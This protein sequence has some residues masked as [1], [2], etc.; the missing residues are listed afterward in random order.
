MQNSQNLIWIDLEMTGLDPE[1][2]V[3]IEM[4]TIVTDSDL[5]TLAEGPVIAIHHSDEV[6]ARMDEW[7]HSHPRQLRLDPA[8]A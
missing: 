5:N 1:N 8:R 4:A 7:E 3:I 2:D 6:L